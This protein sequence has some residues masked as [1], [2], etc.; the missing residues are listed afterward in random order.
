MRARYLLRIDDV[1]PNMHWEN[2]Y[3]LESAL[4]AHSIRPLIGVIPDSRDP[5]LLRQPPCPRDFWSEVH[6]LRRRG[7]KV[8]MHGYQHHYVTAGGGTLAISNKS[9]FAGLPFAEQ[10]AKLRRGR[11]ILHAHGVDTDTFMAPS[12]S[13]DR[14]TERALRET[15]FRVVT[16]GLALYPFLRDGLLFVPQVFSVPRPMPFGVFTFLV[17]PNTL[18]E[19]GLKALCVFL[20]R[21]RDRFID[22]DT[23]GAFLSGGRWNQPAGRMLRALG[24]LV[25]GG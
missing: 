2:F 11:E 16:D 19:P 8:A 10:L 1:A 20:S 5:K 15:K 12:H 4:H 21:H 14:D 17:H 25:R 22:F 24:G 6:R 3:R 13:F 9:E 18:D 7:W 23:A